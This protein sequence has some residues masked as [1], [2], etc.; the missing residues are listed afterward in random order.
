MTV[1]T[2]EEMQEW[3]ELVKRLYAIG[4]FAPYEMWHILNSLAGSSDPAA[5]TLFDLTKYFGAI[6][7]IPEV[8]QVE[9]PGTVRCKNNKP[10]LASLEVD[11]LVA[12]ALWCSMFEMDPYDET[13]RLQELLKA[14]RAGIDDLIESHRRTAK[15]A[16]MPELP[17]N[18]ARALETLTD[19]ELRLCGE[20]G[21]VVAW[22]R[23]HSLPRPGVEETLPG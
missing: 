6:A 1:A 19:E 11:C 3:A 18:V 15:L 14:F 9:Y 12:A 13:E 10:M 17:E 2:D 23:Q 20:A 22:K 5:R 7:E 16:S 8:V 21:K 4:V